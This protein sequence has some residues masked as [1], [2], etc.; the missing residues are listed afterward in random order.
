MAE[1]KLDAPLAEYL[2]DWYRGI[3][4]YRESIGAEQA[5]LEELAQA[6]NAVANDFFFQTMGADT[7]SKWEQIFRIV[8]NPVTESLEFRRARVL[9]RISTRPPFTLGF[10]YRK[11]DELIGP[12]QWTVVVDY[13]RH[14]IYIESDAGS[15]QY[16]SEVEY[17]LNTIK[18][19]HIVYRNTPRV[20]S[21]LLLS[22]S[23]ELTQRI[24]H[25][26]LG[27]WGLGLTPF[28]HEETK[29]GIKMPATP[30]IKDILLTGTAAFVSG[31]VAKARVNGS[32]LIDDIDKDLSGPVLTVTYVVTSTQAKEV[33]QV[34]LLDSAGRAI[35]SSVI[36]VPVA[37]PIIMKHRIPVMEGV[38]ENG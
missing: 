35:T 11:L 15:Q 26:R 27:S 2:P 28:G 19:A 8:P 29:G 34:E 13:P 7:V 16:A 32:I 6:V 18:P 31:Q 10:L 22:E 5:E 24:F 36:Y 12:D 14:T 17:T 30:S 4:D 20:Q 33:T 25:Y 38:I 1:Y 9:N 23:I 3:S 37:E 21:R